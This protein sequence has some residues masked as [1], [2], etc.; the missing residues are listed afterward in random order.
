[1]ANEAALVKINPRE[2]Q[3]FVALQEQ[4]V[5]LLKYAEVRI[6]LKD[7]DLLPATAAL[8]LISNV[9]KATEDM[10]KEYTGPL[11]DYLKSV[12]SAFKLLSDP[13]DQAF[14]ITK[15]KI[16]AHQAE[17]KRRQGEIEEIN[18]LRMEAARKEA[19][20]SGTG[21][22]AGLNLIEPLAP[23]VS[24]VRTELGSL[25]TTKIRKWEVEDLSKVP[26]DYM[27]I[28][29]AKVGKV[30]RAGIPAIAGIRIWLEDSLRITPRSL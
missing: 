7:E 14:K 22:I 29:A 4:I 21:E 28:D 13:L 25:G 11:N 5:G 17:Q 15:D 26:L 1:M 27:M 12:N 23:P 8:A 16:L 3:S 20:L 6:I 9:I 24:H 30:V 2:T 18:R 19:E 10:R